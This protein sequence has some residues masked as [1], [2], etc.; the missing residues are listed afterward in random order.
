MGVLN[1]FLSTVAL[2]LGITG[3]VSI[4]SMITNTEDSKLVPVNYFIGL[5]FVAVIIH[6]ASRLFG[7]LSLGSLTGPPLLRDL[8]VAYTALFLFGALWQTYE[9]SLVD[10]PDWMD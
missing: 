6:S 2:T 8:M 4:K 10:K 1:I 7:S 5:S 9:L 3:I